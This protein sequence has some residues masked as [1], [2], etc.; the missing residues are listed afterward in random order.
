MLNA[1]A[2]ELRCWWIHCA[3]S[4]E[5]IDHGVCEGLK[6]GEAG[7]IAISAVNVGRRLGEHEIPMH[8][9]SF[10]PMLEELQLNNSVEGRRFDVSLL[11]T[12]RY[13]YLMHTRDKHNSNTPL[14]SRQ[15]DVCHASNTLCSSL[16]QPVYLTT[17]C[18]VAM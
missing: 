6:I 5:D 12:S 4:L 3:Q 10:A 16:S 14:T 8:F 17:Q 11:H 13:L 15:A 1:C 7:W 2:A 9:D 18:P